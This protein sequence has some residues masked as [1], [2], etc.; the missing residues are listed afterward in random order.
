[1][2][3]TKAHNVCPTFLPFFSMQK[4]MIEIM[5]ATDKNMKG[6]KINS[7]LNNLCSNLDHD[8]MHSLTSS[9]GGLDLVAA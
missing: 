9:I 8:L 1:M 7:L 2:N 4:V 6:S 3:L 5:R